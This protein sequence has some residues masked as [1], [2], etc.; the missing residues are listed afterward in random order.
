M[1][2][3]IL[4]LYMYICTYLYMCLIYTHILPVD[5]VNIYYLMWISCLCEALGIESEYNLVPNP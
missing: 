2:I 5:S 1:Y 4:H 3:Y